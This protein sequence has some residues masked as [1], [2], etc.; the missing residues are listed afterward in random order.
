MTDITVHAGENWRVV[1]TCCDAD[2]EVLPLTSGADVQFRVSNDDGGIIVT[3]S[4]GEGGTI[5]D[6]EGGVVEFTIPVNE[7]TSLGLSADTVYWYEARV[8]KGDDVWEQ[9]SGR[10]KIVPSLFVEPI[11]PLLMEFRLRFEEF[12]SLDDQL[13]K[14]YIADATREVDDDGLVAA[15]DRS[16]AILYLAAHF[17]SLRKSAYTQSTAGGGVTAGLV[18]SVRIEDRAVTYGGVG[19]TAA[20]TGAE[21]TYYGQQYLR[22]TRRRTRWLLRG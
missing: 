21:Q 20:K 13:I 12:S 19:G 8:V 17:V 5:T 7:Q 2:G 4:V 16:A 14:L 1:L 10:F 6:D 3:L 15:A 9:A 11:D 22:L 18:Q